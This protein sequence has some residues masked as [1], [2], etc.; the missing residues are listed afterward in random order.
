MSELPRLH[1]RVAGRA[2]FFVRIAILIYL[3]STRTILVQ[4]SGRHYLAVVGQHIYMQQT[5]FIASMSRKK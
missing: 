1:S 2:F 4:G 5:F 3:S